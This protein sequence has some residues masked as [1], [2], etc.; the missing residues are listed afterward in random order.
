MVWS[1]PLIH[2]IFLQILMES[3]QGWWWKPLIFLRKWKLSV[4]SAC[5]TSLFNW[6][7]QTYVARLLLSLNSTHHGH[8][9]TYSSY[10]SLVLEVWSRIIDRK[11]LFLHFGNRCCLLYLQL[12]P[13]G[14]FT[15]ALFSLVVLKELMCAYNVMSLQVFLGKGL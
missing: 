14:C 11:G 4:G 12:F 7:F 10:S 5:H 9:H 8:R 1:A 2:V 3:A 15:F 6:P 13:L